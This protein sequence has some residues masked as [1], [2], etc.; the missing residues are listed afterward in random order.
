MSTSLLIAL[1]SREQDAEMAL[2]A[3]LASGLGP[4]DITVL[5]KDSPAE[6]GHADTHSD[7]LSKGSFIGAGAGLIMGLS[8]FAAPGLGIL[9]AAG[10]LASLVAG[11][12]AGGIIGSLA[13]MGF[14]E[15]DANR[16]QDAVSGG[17]ILVAI[18]TVTPDK[19]TELLRRAGAY[20]IE[21]Q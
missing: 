18:R 1:F 8:A 20:Q 12:A 11:A 9:A 21:L 19:Y 10:P 3:L 7:G 13:D 4:E 6:R 17:S 2:D 16:Y 15:T 14:S 5:T